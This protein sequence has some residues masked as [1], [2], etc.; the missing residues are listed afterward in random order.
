MNKPITRRSSALPILKGMESLHCSLLRLVSGRLVTPL[1]FV[2][3][4][5]ENR[6]IANCGWLHNDDRRESKEHNLELCKPR[7]KL[8]SH[9]PIRRVGGA[10]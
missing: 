3:S 5:F 1:S 2:Q 10:S 9:F 7:H 8:S 4:Y 6:A